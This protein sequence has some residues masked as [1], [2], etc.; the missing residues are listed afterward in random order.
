MTEKIHCGK[1]CMLL[2]FGE[3]IKRR[4]YMRAIPSEETV[5]GYYNNVC[6]RC[7]SQL[8]LKSVNIKTEGRK[9]WHT[10]KS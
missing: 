4:L 8:T 10:M 2:Y 5:L 6:P 9:T 3:E 1:C 7:G